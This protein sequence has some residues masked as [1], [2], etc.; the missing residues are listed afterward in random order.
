MNLLE[1]QGHSGL[2]YLS[3]CRSGGRSGEGRDSGEPA[4]APKVFSYPSFWSNS[5]SSYWG[6]LKKLR[7]S[8][9]FQISFLTV[10]VAQNDFHTILLYAIIVQLKICIKSNSDVSYW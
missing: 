5:N 6:F 2:T 10:G 9:N 3:M 7:Q 1:R 8:N 4:P